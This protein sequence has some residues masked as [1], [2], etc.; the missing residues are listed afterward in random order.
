MEEVERPTFFNIVQG[1]KGDVYF[2][3]HFT[4]RIATK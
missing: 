3:L 1:R 2:Y 4:G